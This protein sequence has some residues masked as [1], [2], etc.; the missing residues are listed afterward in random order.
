MSAETASRNAWL[1]IPNLLSLGRLAA[2]PLLCWWIV[3]ERRLAATILFVV[4]AISDNLDGR[5]AR[6]TGTVTDLGVVLDPLSDRVL[7]MAALVTLM[8][9]GM[10][11]P[12]LAVP[13]LARDA[14]VSLAF[15]ALAG[16][17]YGKPQVK[18]VGKAA[19]FALLTALPALVYQG[20]LRPFG[21]VV[22]A[23]GGVLYY[24]AGAAYAVDIVRWLRG[25][26]SAPPAAG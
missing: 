12:W 20:S 3:Q 7:V 1:T 18:L 13:V 22:F 23:A 24:V 17:G 25:G 8:A 9:K 2:T 15:L 16:K 19:T 4:M 21:L 6:A 26:R 10:V 14:I 11:P 5:I